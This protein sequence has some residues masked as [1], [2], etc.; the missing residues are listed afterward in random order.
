MN[1]DATLN[2]L[3]ALQTWQG[4]LHRQGSRA[5]PLPQ[6]CTSPAATQYQ[7]AKGYD[8]FNSKRPEAGCIKVVLKTAA[9]QEAPRTQRGEAPAGAA[10][11]QE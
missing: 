8:M 10:A 11:E 9:A 2:R 5:M 4:G 6:H 3:G 1:G 7:A